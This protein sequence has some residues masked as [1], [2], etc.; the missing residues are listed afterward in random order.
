MIAPFF[1]TPQGRNRLQGI[2]RRLR[3]Q[4]DMSRRDIL[5]QV[6]AWHDYRQERYVEPA[7]EGLTGP[8]GVYHFD[9]A[10]RFILSAASTLSSEGA[11][12]FMPQAKRPRDAL[13]QIAKAYGYRYLAAVRGLRDALAEA[14]VPALRIEQF[15]RQRDEF[16][17]TFAARLS[18]AYILNDRGQTPTAARD[19]VATL[20]I[21]MM[22]VCDWLDATTERG[23]VPMLV[24]QIQSALE[25]LQAPNGGRRKHGR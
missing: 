16:Q 22:R 10:A 17:Q 6:A 4:L 18:A 7:L 11:A 8:A 14:G 25:K 19:A 24:T 21:E 9:D 1:D 3:H 5:G 20:A 15:D 2:D 23:R 12:P 13:E